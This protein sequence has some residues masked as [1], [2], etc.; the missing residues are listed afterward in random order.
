MIHFSNDTWYEID[1]DPTDYYPRLGEPAVV[2]KDNTFHIWYGSYNTVWQGAVYANASDPRGP[3]TKLGP[4]L[5]G[6]GHPDVVY[7]PERDLYV[8]W[9]GTSV[10]NIATAS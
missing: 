5:D 1:T 3:W 4:V 7:D 10:N 6:V 9:Y 2:F 8:M